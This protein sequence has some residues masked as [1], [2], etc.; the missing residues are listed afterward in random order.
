MSAPN[1]PDLTPEERQLLEE[2][3]AARSVRDLIAITEAKNADDAYF[4]AK[5][6]WYRLRELTLPPT[7]TDGFPG[8]T[9]TVDGVD[10]VVHGVTH[11][12]TEQEHEFLRSHVSHLLGKGATVYC[13]QGLRRMYFDD[14]DGVREFDDYAWSTERCRQLGIES[15][16][17]ETDPD[18][19][20]DDIAELTSG[21]RTAVFSLIESGKK[22]YGARF[23][24]ALGDVASLFLTSRE[25]MAK[26]DDYEGFRRSREAAMDPTKLGE[27]QRYYKK[28][29][30]PQPVERDW[31]RRHDP[32][33]EIFTHARNERMSDYAVYDNES[34][35]VHL[36]V[37]A[38][39]QPGV[40]YYLRQHRDGD[41]S[42]G[43]FEFHD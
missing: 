21:L 4:R 6:D 3:Q 15:C 38:A 39:H 17:E 12:N 26:G 10:F 9:V 40:V 5:P 22:V 36:I 20:A 43:E 41:R 25:E 24:D 27:L 29:L 1:G 18:G 2:I 30:L 11:T 31:L 8:D 19:D 28:K 35:E 33:I 13:E 32:E 23:A 7:P 14:F 34:D 16:V 37:G 42:V